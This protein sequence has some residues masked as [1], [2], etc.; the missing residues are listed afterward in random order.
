M[1]RL[2]HV[3]DRI[4]EFSAEIDVD[5]AGVDFLM[6]GRDHGFGN[7]AE[8]SEHGKSKLGEDVLHHHRY[9]DFV[10]DQQDAIA[11]LEAQRKAGLVLADAAVCAA[12]TCRRIDPVATRNGQC[13]MQSFR[14]PVKSGLAVE[15]ALDAGANH[16]DAEARRLRRKDGRT[17]ALGPSQQETVG[18]QFPRHR[19][20]S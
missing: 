9:Q 3:G 7:P 18:L 20:A 12:M 16:A 19:D 10:F 13:A 8:G 1:P 2:E 6:H 11:G 5:D 15:L 14:A 4:D 17:T